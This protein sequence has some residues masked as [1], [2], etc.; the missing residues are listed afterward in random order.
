VT[1]LES[2]ARAKLEALLSPDLLVALDEYVRDL[3]D[4]RLADQTVASM[5]RDWYTLEEAARLLGCSYGAAR[6]RARRGRLEVRRQGRTVLV[7]AR[8]LKLR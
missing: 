3:V 8:S 1:E 7:S 4:E 2:T 6:M 5:G